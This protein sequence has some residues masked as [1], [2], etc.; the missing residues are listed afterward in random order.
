MFLMTLGLG[1]FTVLTRYIAAL[2]GTVYNTVE[3]S[4]PQWSQKV[5]MAG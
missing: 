1:N 5:T 4:A 3:S 2:Q